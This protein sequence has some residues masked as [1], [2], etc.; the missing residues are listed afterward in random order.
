MQITWKDENQGGAIEDKDVL[1]VHSEF[2]SEVTT[3]NKLR[4]EKERLTKQIT[5]IQEKLRI[6]TG[7]LEAVIDT[8]DIQ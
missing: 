2:Y 7:K 8:L 1:I 4:A 5:D 6:T 3:T